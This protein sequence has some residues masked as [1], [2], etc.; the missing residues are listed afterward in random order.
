MTQRRRAL[1]AAL[2][3]LGLGGAG[4]ASAQ[5]LITV[6]VWPFDSHWVGSPAQP[7]EQQALQYLLPD[8]LGQALSGSSRVRLVERQRLDQVLQ[9]QKLG[10]SALADDQ[11]RLRLGRLVG[12]RWMAFGSL[13][14]IGGAWQMDVRMVD[15]ELAQ[16]LMTASASGAQTEYLAAMQQIGEQF[17]KQIK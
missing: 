4:L 12:A 11:T 1:C 17:L 9:E 2:L 5:D 14:H 16:V 8:L 15:V 6:C 7:G 10:S 13:M 3:G